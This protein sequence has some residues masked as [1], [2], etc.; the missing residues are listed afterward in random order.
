MRIKKMVA[1]FMIGIFCSITFSY[2]KIMAND[3][4]VK[5]YS[6]K[7]KENKEYM[8]I[9]L[10]IPQVKIIN[11]LTFE[12][13]INN[14]IFS[15]INTWKNDL[16]DLAKKYKEDFEKANAQWKPFVLNIKYNDPYNKNNLLSLVLDYYQ[17]TGGAHGLTTR[18]AYN[19]ALNEEKSLEL[20][21][22]FKQDYDYKLVINN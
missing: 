5:I 22:I 11:N 15:D 9:D 6:D 14:V 1:I 2:M 10:N 17:Y 3:I 12:S 7:V 13:K 18:I 20:K 16:I 8:N 4:K 19:F 21:D